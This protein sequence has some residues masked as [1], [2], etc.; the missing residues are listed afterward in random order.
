MNEAFSEFISD[1]KLNVNQIRFVNLI[2]DYIVTNGNIED[3]RVLM[4]EPFKSAGSITTLFKNDMDVAR[5][6]MDTVATIKGNSVI[7]A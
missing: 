6:I 1:R 3:N 4:E 7:I 2:I 5:R